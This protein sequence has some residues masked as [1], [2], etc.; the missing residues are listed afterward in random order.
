MTW[1]GTGLINVCLELIPDVVVLRL[2]RGV[3]VP[4]PG[5]DFPDWDPS[6]PQEPLD[7][8]DAVAD[9]NTSGVKARRRFRRG[10]CNLYVGPFVLLSFSW[11]VCLYACPGMR[12][13]M[14]T[15]RVSVQRHWGSVPSS[16]CYTFALARKKVTNHVQYRIL[17]QLS[18]W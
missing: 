11:S 6:A 8:D 18:L 7:Q 10:K 15:C 13:H 9:D 4:V 12:A 3:I 17:S 2:A 16:L 14:R 1:C 5:R